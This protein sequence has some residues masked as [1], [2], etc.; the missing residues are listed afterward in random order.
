V[1]AE[2]GAGFWTADGLTRL[3]STTAPSQPQNL[4]LDNHGAYPLAVASHQANAERWVDVAPT[5]DS[6]RDHPFVL[7]AHGHAPAVA[8]NAEQTPKTS[9]GV[10]LT[11][12]ANHN[13]SKLHVQH[14][15]TVPRRLTPLECERLQGFP[16]DWTQVEYNGKPMADGPRYRMMGNAVTVNVIEWIGRRIVAAEQARAEE[17]A[18]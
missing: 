7:P 11:M 12:R 2:T 3:R 10:S 5:L 9:E 18:A 13:A 1:I 8:F 4:V 15:G 14:S 16:D 17:E 6:D